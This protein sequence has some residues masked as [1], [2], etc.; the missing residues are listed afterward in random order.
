M[1]R[2]V[3][4]FRRIDYEGSRTAGGAAGRGEG[5]RA[6]E[7]FALIAAREGDTVRLDVAVTDAQATTMAAAGLSRYFIQM[8]G[9]WRLSG[10]VGGESVADSGAG[11]FETFVG[12]G[13]RR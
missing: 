2:Q 9:D 11:F 3:L 13:K 6:P 4:R 1:S 5:V 7:R 10:R 8:R 12:R